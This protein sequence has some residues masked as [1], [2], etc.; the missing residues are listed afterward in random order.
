MKID[1]PMNVLRWCLFCCSVVLVPSPIVLAQED[2]EPLSP[3]LEVNRLNDGKP[4]I[5]KEMFLEIDAGLES[6]GGNINGPCMV[7]IPEWVAKEDRADPTAVY[8]LYFAHH[9]DEFIR[10]AWAADIEGPYTLYNT[11]LKDKDED[12]QLGRGVLDLGS[13]IGKSGK[14]EIKVSK[15]IVIKN[16]VASPDVIIDDVNKRFL[17]FFHGHANKP[18][19]ES[20][21]ANTGKQKTY[22]ATSGT[23]LNFNMPDGSNVL[24]GGVNGG[25]NQRI[26]R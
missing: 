21:V 8:Y 7:R 9:G 17:M 6:E 5:T 22:V 23:G 26:Y 10:M 16:N 11:H 13:K 15:E 18:N 24:S 20:N 2:P 12:G 19:Y 3:A 4:I 25:Q 1:I 14:P